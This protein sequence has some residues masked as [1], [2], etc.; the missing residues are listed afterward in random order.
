MKDTKL[1]RS[2]KLSEAIKSS[3]AVRLGID[4]TPPDEI[5]PRI[6]L[7]AQKIL[8]PVRDEYGIPITP[9]SWYRC[10]ELNRALNSA[11]TSQHIKGRAVDFEVPTID[12][13]ELAYFVKENLDFDQLILEFYNPRNPSSGWIHCSYVS[14]DDNRGEVLT[15]QPKGILNAGLPK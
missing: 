4:N 9:S 13:L 14:E 2:F 7:V 12:N 5:V 6:A 1:S 15:I 11:D 8:Q 10:L 3:T